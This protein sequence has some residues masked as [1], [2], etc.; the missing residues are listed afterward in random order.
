M[1]KSAMQLPVTSSTL[2]CH[3]ICLY[4]LSNFEHDIVGN[5]KMTPVHLKSSVV[6]DR[7]L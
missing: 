2:L 5:K 6:T 4:T 3:A 1:G 7:K